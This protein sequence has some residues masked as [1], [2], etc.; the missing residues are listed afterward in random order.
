M[1]STVFGPERVAHRNHVI[2]MDVGLPPVLATLPDAGLVADEV[3]ERLFH[4][5]RGAYADE[6][7]GIVVFGNDGFAKDHRSRREVAHVVGVC[8]HLGLDLEAF[9]VCGEGCTWALVVS[10]PSEESVEAITAVLHQETFAAWF[11]ASGVP[12][13]RGPMWA[14]RQ[15]IRSRTARAG[16]LWS[17][18]GF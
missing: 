8:L 3:T 9:G 15:F 17:R 18:D 13:S 1:T 7:G 10:C 6:G 16:H 12:V 11:E 4:H 2:T 5:H 14:V